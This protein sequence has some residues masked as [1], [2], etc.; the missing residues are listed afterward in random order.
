M[1]S[2]NKP[3][4][5]A[6]VA[7]NLE[8]GGLTNV[9]QNVFKLLDSVSN[10]EVQ[11]I[12]LDQKIHIEKDKIILLSNKKLAKYFQLYKIL[13]V[14]KWDYIIDLRYRINPL[15]EILITKFI[16][17]L[18]NIIYNV[19][20]SRLETYLPKNKGLTNWLYGKSYKI[21][22][23]A[24]GNE[25]LVIEKY[26]L[27]NTKTIY[28]PLDL[29]AIIKSSNEVLEINF[30]YI[31]AVGRIEEVKQF[32]KLI[33]A[34]SNSILV[35]RNIKLVIVGDGSQLSKCK[36]KVTELEIQDNVIFEGFSSNPYKYMKQ[37]KFFVLSSKYEG[38]GLV[39]AESLACGTPVISFDLQ[40]GPNEIITHKENGLLVKNQDFE[41]L[42]KAMNNLEVDKDLYNHCKLNSIKSISK[43]A[44]K[45]IKKDWLNLL[46]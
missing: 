7:Y 20:S 43:F 12:L 15:T 5:I 21:V 1:N 6:I 17:P 30:D 23:G 27:N 44:M 33:E 19:H 11:L 22:C 37:A 35:D 14:K 4:K 24:K 42:T 39:L 31:L 9:I 29:E 3:T 28:N 45:N 8:P 46:Q 10:F 26:S 36:E 38:F 2:Q 40:T 18:T 13:N 32:E 41:E 25:E 34:Y 16:Y